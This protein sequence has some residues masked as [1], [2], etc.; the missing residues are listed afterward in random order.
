MVEHG[1]LFVSMVCSEIGFTTDIIAL[2]HAGT[3]WD[4]FILPCYYGVFYIFCV[5]ERDIA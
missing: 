2:A 5:T 1:L 4:N 3:I